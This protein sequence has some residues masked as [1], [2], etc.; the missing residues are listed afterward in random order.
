MLSE[1]PELSKVRKI[2]KGTDERFRR[3]YGV[4]FFEL[5]KTLSQE[6]RAY[7][8]CTLYAS[9]FVP[10]LAGIVPFV[11]LQSILNLN[12]ATLAKHLK[13]LKKTRLVDQKYLKRDRKHCEYSFY[14]STDTG[15]KA[16]I[17]LLGVN[18]EDILNYA[19]FLTEK[20]ML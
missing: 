19:T 8:L 13:L 1:N 11:G 15:D 18:R 17:E 9:K 14:S 10:D 2:V 20:L 16:V 3:E 12:P 7:I 4:G 6:T 5:A